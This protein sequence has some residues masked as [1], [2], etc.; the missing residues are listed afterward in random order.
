MIS[1]V[2]MMT[3]IIDDDYDDVDDEKLVINFQ[4][5]STSVPRM[6]VPYF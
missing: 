6:C 5:L 1:M 4:N 2:L 3:T